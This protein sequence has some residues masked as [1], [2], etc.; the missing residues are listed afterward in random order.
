MEYRR[1]SP[2]A[3]TLLGAALLMGNLVFF[4]RQARAAGT[5]LQATPTAQEPIRRTV[6]VTGTGSV[7]AAP[8]LAVVVMGVQTDAET[9]SEALTQNNTQM[10]GLIA[11]LRE[12]GI[13]QADI[14]TQTL[15][16]YPRYE[17]PPTPRAGEE[18]VQSRLVG[19]TAVNTVQ[20]RVREL[21]SLGD[22]LD[23]AVE[24]GSNQI[25]NIY[26]DLQNPVAQ[27]D[28]AREAAMQ[29]ATRKAQQLAELANAEL[30]P[31][32]SIQESSRVPLP[33]QRDAVMMEQAASSVPISPGQQ[34]L[35]ADVS[36][37]WELLVDTETGDE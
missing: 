15:Q 1:Y 13:A 20:V 10:D 16:L 21:D 14:R 6:S 34:T 31:V 8:D 5:N 22:L 4:P 26:F 11:A 33:F 18:T 3:F 23:Q 24:A 32:I 2:L 27:M 25:S 7:E 19:Y 17:T 30:G 29:D 36:V 28:Q 37:T 9:A 12:A 35:T